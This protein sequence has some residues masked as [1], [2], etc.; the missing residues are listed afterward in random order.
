MSS[1]FYYLTNC[2]VYSCFNEIIVR[3]SHITHAQFSNIHFLAHILRTCALIPAVGPFLQFI[4]TASWAPRTLVVSHQ[5]AGG[6][7]ERTHEPSKNS[8]VKLN[9]LHMHQGSPLV[10]NS[11]TLSRSLHR[12]PSAAQGHLHTIHPTE[13]WSIQ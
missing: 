13:P 11:R 3:S 2:N 10:P 6:R 9:H 8:R 1:V 5:S 12:H 7:S 4:P